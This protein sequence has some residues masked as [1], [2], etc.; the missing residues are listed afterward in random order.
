MT[1]FITDNIFEVALLLTIV[2]LKIG[3][4]VDKV[5]VKKEL[6]MMETRLATVENSLGRLRATNHD[7]RN[8]VSS[9]SMQIENKNNEN[10]NKTD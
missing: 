8:I 7:I 6:K 5:K 3:W 9:L 10:T 1:Y 2:S 4:M